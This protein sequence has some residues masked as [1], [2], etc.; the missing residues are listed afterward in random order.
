MVIIV[1]QIK[2]RMMQEYDFLGA[3][4]FSATASTSIQPSEQVLQNILSFARS[5]QYVNAEGLQIKIF[6]N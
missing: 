4:T 2:A 1:Q 3:D 6:L 5:Y